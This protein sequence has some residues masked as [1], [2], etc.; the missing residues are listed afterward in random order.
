MNLNKTRNIQLLAGCICLSM[1][2]CSDDV[3]S[4][5]GGQTGA[6]D[7]VSYIGKAVGNFSADEWYPGGELGTTLNV[8]EGCYED[9][10]PATTNMG[11]TDQF[12]RG[13]MFFERNVTID[14]PPF[15]GLGPAS[16]RKSCIDCHPGYGHGKRQDSYKA[17][18]GNGY[19]LVIYHPD[20]GANSND[21]PYISEVTGMPQTQAVSPFLPPVD[22]DK[23]TITWKNVTA[24]ES[25]LSMTFPNGGDS[26]ELIYPEVTIAPSAF[27][28][29]PVPTNY[30]VRLESTIGII[31]TGLIDAIPD[32]SLKKQ[33]ELT[34]RYSEVNPAM[35]D[36]EAND[37]ASTAYYTNW[38]S[39]GALADG[40]AVT[41]KIKRYT[42]ALTRASLQ[43]GA[44]ANAMWNIPNVSRPDRPKLYTTQA[45]ADAMSMNADVISAIKRDPTSPYYA[46]GTDEGIADAVKN[47]L[48]PNT[49]QF[50]NKWHNFTPD[51]STDNF[52]AFMVWHRGLSIPRARNLNDPDVQRGKKL[53]ME[54]GCATCHRPSWTTGD[55][56]YWTPDVIKGRPLPKYPKQ[57]IYPYSDF[58]Q[59]KLY[60][61]NDIHGSWCRTT[62][63]WGRGL[64][65]INTGAED[66]LHDCRA[67][68]EVEAIMWHC[69]SK[70]S[71]AYDSAYK[72]YNL[73]KADRD[74]VVKFL[75]SI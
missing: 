36:K 37:W 15:N 26:Y 29:Y 12:N 74:A 70:K 52:Y 67:R 53:F 68:N 60:M 22:E 5:G 44:G 64:S 13:E 40:T 57:K 69:Y 47:L 30:A 66:R 55:D 41:G 19:L 20:D 58:V 71:Q 61:A 9:E 39:P 38:T 35:W 34:A 48:S 14:T 43:D 59:H 49:N 11:L 33:Y 62:P 42:Y 75:R 25:G 46:D 50:D 4:T 72:F 6:V 10:T 32:D 31:G 2:A 27:N 63:L 17:G 73:P 16:V 21:G 54:M 45:W 3:P 1:A 23:I 51:M 24:M 28:T 65:L 7:D 56:N 8:S 18:F